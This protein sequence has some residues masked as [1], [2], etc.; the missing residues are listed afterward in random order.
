MRGRRQIPIHVVDLLLEPFVQHLVSLVQDLKG[1]G[2]RSKEE[3]KE[4]R[5][6]EEKR[7]KEGVEK[8]G[9][10]EGEK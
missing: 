2:E 6:G 4:E 3:R 10:D 5:R 7:R 8:G 1:E 9:N